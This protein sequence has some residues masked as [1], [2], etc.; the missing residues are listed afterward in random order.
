MS[1]TSYV[2][3]S[4]ITFKIKNCVQIILP[5]L[6]M[7]EESDVNTLVPSEAVPNIK[8]TLY[9]GLVLSARI[10]VLV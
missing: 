9:Y 7:F 4:N 3:C 2:R 6:F 8:V 1:I 10:H 5:A